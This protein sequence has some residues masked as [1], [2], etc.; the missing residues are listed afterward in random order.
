VERGRGIGLVW[1]SFRMGE[2][3]L[4]WTSL[5]GFGWFEE[6]YELYL[7]V[8]GLGCEFSFIR[9]ILSANALLNF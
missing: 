6:G 3:G 1:E 9:R 4:H 5:D 2:D 8:L 7:G